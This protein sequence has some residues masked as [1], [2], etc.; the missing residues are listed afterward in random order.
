MGFASI[1]WNCRC[2]HLSS[3][4]EVMVPETLSGC[5]VI[6]VLAGFD[7]ESL[8]IGIQLIGRPQADLEVLQIAHAYEQAPEDVICRSPEFGGQ[9]LTSRG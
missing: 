2:R 6:S 9:E 3:L 7:D 8:P 4:T 5:P 1:V